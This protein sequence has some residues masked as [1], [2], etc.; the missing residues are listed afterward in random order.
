MI[1]ILEVHTKRPQRGKPLEV[2]SRKIIGQEEGDSS[3]VLIP[4]ADYVLECMERDG[5]LPGRAGGGRLP[6]I[7]EVVSGG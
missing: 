1:D 7:G 3:E 6:L 5:L 2:I 4:L